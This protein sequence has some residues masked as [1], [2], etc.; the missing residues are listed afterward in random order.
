M[1][2]EGCLMF[3]NGKEVIRSVSH[4]KTSEIVSRKALNTRECTSLHQGQNA[5]LQV[6]SVSSYIRGL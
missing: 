5:D 3:L 2:G 6:P 4:S 1:D